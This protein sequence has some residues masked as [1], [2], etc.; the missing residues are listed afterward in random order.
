[1]GPICYCHL[2]RLVY[3]TFLAILMCFI[4]V[5]TFL[6]TFGPKIPLFGPKT[7]NSGLQLSYYL[8]YINIDEYACYRLIYSL[9]YMVICVLSFLPFLTPNWGL[10][11][12]S[13]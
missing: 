4:A 11:L 10:P 2:T 3:I 12:F 8:Y 6:G 5:I 13:H 1:M 7:Y 9:L